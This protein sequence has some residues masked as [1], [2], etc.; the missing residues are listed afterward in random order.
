MFTKLLFYKKVFGFFFIPY[1]GNTG[2]VGVRP[3][4]KALK[5][6]SHVGF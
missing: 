5:W 6:D 3:W 4:A 2:K 1:I